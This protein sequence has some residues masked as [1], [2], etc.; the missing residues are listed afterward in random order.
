[1]IKKL[2]NLLAVAAVLAACAGCGVKNDPE[3]PPASEQT[4]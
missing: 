1:M 3:P 4:P 2:T